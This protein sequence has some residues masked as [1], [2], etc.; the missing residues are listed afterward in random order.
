MAV[1]K[2][3]KPR[4]LAAL[5]AALGALSISTYAVADARSDAKR[6]FKAGMELI[7][8]GRFE[9]GIKALEKADEILPHPSVKYNIKRAKAQKFFKEGMANIGEGRHQQGIG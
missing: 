5:F 3:L 8:K 7:K 9:E 6:Y 1:G 2:W 4:L